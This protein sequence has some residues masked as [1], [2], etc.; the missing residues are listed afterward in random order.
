MDRF[1]DACTKFGLTINLGK[2]KVMYTPALGDP[3]VESDIY[4]YGIRLEVVENFIYL[5][6]W[7]SDW[8]LGQ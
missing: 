8:F 2:T 7:L 6:S 4:V 1:A 3:Y 5:G